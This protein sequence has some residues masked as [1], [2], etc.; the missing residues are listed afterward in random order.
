MSQLTVEAWQ[1]TKVGRQTL[2][3][4]TAAE[5]GG[6][7]S[8]YRACSARPHSAANSARAAIQTGQENKERHEKKHLQKRGESAP[9]AL[10][11]APSR[12]AEVNDGALAPPKARH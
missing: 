1:Q 11:R 3:R 8:L 2:S 9:A 4:P 6:E 10:P 7:A 12:A 5:G